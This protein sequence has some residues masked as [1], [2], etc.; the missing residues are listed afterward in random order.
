MR[1]MILTLRTLLKISIDMPTSLVSEL[2]LFFYICVSNRIGIFES[3]KRN[4][5]W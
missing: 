5:Y 3:L 1:Q 4:M 2:I